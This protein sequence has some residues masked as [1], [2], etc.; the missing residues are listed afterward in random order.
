MKAAPAE[1][2]V[3]DLPGD[4]HRGLLAVQADHFADMRAHE[5][6]PLRDR[7]RTVGV[8]L[9]KLAKQPRIPHRT[10]REHDRAAAGFAPDLIVFFPSG[11]TAVR[12]DPHSRQRFADLPDDAV[13]DRPGIKRLL[14]PAMHGD[15][16][17][18]ELRQP[19]RQRQ[20]RSRVLRVDNADLGRQHMLRTLPEQGETSQC[21]VDM[22]PEL[23]SG[24]LLRNFRNRAA[25]IEVE[26]VELVF[27]QHVERDFQ[28][29]LVRADQLDAEKRLVAA[30]QQHRLRSFPG[31]GERR[32]IDHLGKG[33]NAA[34][35]P[36]RPAVRQIGI[37][38][39]RRHQQR[40]FRIREQT[41]FITSFL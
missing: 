41:H 39:K 18:A 4:P 19:L 13:G 12:H 35:L 28:M 3:Q 37:T 30:A 29:L 40:P 9:G 14:D 26:H 8:A 25:E 6:Q 33:V 7:R 10:A 38:R 2:V 5:F 22:P 17:R 16:L 31:I 20:R 24:P 34:A 32:G 36:C 27:V 11:H 21:P 23:S 1:I 15:R